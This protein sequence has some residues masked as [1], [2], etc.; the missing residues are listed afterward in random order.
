MTR[1][2]RI[3]VLVAALAL[4]AAGTLAACGTGGD[5]GP[6]ATA[7]ATQ[8]AT[9]PDDKLDTAAT[10]NIRLTLEPTSLDIFGTAGTAVEQLLLDNVY[11]SLL[12][13][14]TA[15]KD[16]IVPA[17]ASSWDESPDGL[18][19]TLHLA[20][21]AKFHDGSA[22][23]AADAVWSLR[24][25]LAPGSKSVRAA[26]FTSVADVTDP[27]PA[28]VR[29]TLKQRD[30]Q[31]LWTL[32]GRG[33]IVYKQGTD[34]A[35]LDG[36]ENG[37]GP[38]R[39][40]QWNRGSSIT[41]ERN[42][43]YAGVKPKVA[44]VVFHYIKDPNAANNAESTGQTDIQ[45]AADPTLLQPFTGNGKFTVL[46]GTTTDKFV[47]AFNGNQ[48][49]FTNPDVRHAIRQAIDK[50]AAVSTYGAGTVIGSDVPPQDPW[51]EDLTAID[52]YNPDNA[53]KLLAAA[54][55][56]NGLPLT[57]DVPDIYPPSI[58]DLLVSDLKKVG[59][60]LTVRQVEFQTW[61]QKVYTNKDFQLS[62][63]DHAEAHDI[64]NYTKPTYYFGYDNKQ[65]QQW[66]AQARTAGSDAERD[67]LL[68]NVARQIS[69]DAAT[70]W[71]LLVQTT[72]VVRTGVYGV[73][74]AETSN[75]YN[76]S[77]LAVGR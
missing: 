77:G 6:G 34:F 44:K 58:T 46:Q 27:D 45:V 26:N 75:R 24:Q 2:H 30:T 62:L 66:Y 50:K 48:A 51:Y 4:L 72:T 59:V 64:D 33:G 71:L 41:L 29:I 63:V 18:T 12:S 32:A 60:T 20:P 11:Q 55:F 14:D 57:L 49:P 13:I 53:K 22:L 31:L 54:G 39:L 25:Q 7:S 42:D 17:L 16:K 28:T 19:Y 40:T 67:T 68:K 65:V 1:A 8:A 76:L 38:F 21:G 35:T 15:A 37:S 36:T 70:D 56:G 5:T 73:P 52:A 47:L 10:V 43:A 69:Q 23:T 3:P 61:L 74:Q 9:P